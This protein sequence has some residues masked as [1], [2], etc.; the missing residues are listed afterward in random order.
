MCGRYAST[1]SDDAVR[2]LYDVIDTVGELPGASYNVAP[3]QQVRVVLDRREDGEVRRQ[4]RAARW[5]LVPSWA[6][7]LSIGSRLINARSETVT[8]K[9]AY[10]RAAVSR[11]CVLPADGYFEWEKL[12]HPETGKTTKAPFYLHGDGLLSMAGLYELWPDP[13]KDRDDPDRWV[14]TTTILTTAATDALGYIH[15][16]AP[17]LLP[18]QFVDPWLD[19]RMTDA[20]DV[21]VL[22]ASLPEPVLDPYRISTKVNSPK[23]NSPDLLDPV[24]A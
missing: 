14:W 9:P 17:V 23:N 5:G 24:S 3:T 10:R 11:R 15:D 8:E 21:K 18:R 16:R 2:R 12:E 13:S 20:D 1:A 7:D 6:K 4:L 22:L 19:P